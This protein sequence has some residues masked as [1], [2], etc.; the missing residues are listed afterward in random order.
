MNMYIYIRI[1]R[2]SLLITRDNQ[3]KYCIFFLATS[4]V[5][6]DLIKAI[7]NLVMKKGPYFC[8]KLLITLSHIKKITYL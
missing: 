2:F 7:V 6:L 5:L 1:F 4:P 3:Q 8:I